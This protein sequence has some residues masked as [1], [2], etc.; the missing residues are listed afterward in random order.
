MNEVLEARTAYL[1]AKED[2]LLFNERKKA[3]LGRSIARARDAGTSQTQIMTDLKLSREQ[4]R[5]FEKAFR[6]WERNHPDKPLDNAII[7][8]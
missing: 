1:Q 6:D 5:A 8:K 7:L 3:L 4:V 2:T